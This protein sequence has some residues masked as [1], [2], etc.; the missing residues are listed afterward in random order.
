MPD[1][2]TVYQQ[3]CIRLTLPEEA[4]VTLFRDASPSSI[5]G[6]AAGVLPFEATAAQGK[7]G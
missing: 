2:T 6:S 3:F 4:P 5:T 1:A 7:W